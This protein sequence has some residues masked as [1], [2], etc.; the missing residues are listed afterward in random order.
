[1]TMKNGG[2]LKRDVERELGR[3]PSIDAMHDVVDRIAVA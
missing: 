2:E 1:M 3:D